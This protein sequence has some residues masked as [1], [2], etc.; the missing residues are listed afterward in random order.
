MKNLLLALIILL[1]PPL[2]TEE[3]TPLKANL[4]SNHTMIAAGQDFQLLVEVELESGWHAYWKNPGDSGMAP[5]INWKLPEGLTVTN[6]DW[7]TPEKFESE[8]MITYGYSSSFPLL[9]TVK[10]SKQL[11]EGTL[12]IE[13]DL[14][15]IICS[16]ETCLPGNTA[17]K[18]KIQVGLDAKP[19][20]STKFEKAESV[21]PKT[22]PHHLV[23]HQVG[24]VLISYPDDIALNDAPRFFPENADYK[25]ELKSSSKGVEIPMPDN[26]E[27][28]LKGVLVFGN[29]A[30][31]MDLPLPK[32]APLTEEEPM[33]LVWAL[34]F[35]VAGGLILNLMPCV[36]PVVSL[37][38]MSFVKMAGNSRIELMK[39]GVSFTFGVLVSFWIL[40]A[41]LVGLQATGQA[42]GWGFQLQD[43]LF[44]SALALLFTLLALNLFGVFEFGT[45]LATAAGTASL[46]TT[47]TKGYRSS[48]FSGMFATAIATPC[49]GPFMGSALGYAIGQPAYISFLIF[50]ALGLG[51]SLPYLMIGFFPSSIRWLPK[52]GAWMESFKQFLGFLMLATVIWLLWVFNGQTSELGLFVMLF[53]LLTASIG[54][55][56]YGRFGA[57]H[58]NK[59]SRKISYFMT[60][61]FLIGSLGMI[62]MASGQVS[63]PDSHEIAHAGWEPFSAEK[64]AEL[65]K[66][67]TPILIDFTAKWCLICQANHLVM[68]N[69]EVTKKFA[70]NGVV[71]MKA[72]W[73]RYD[74]VITEALKK[75]GRSGVPLYVY[76]SEGEEPVILP[77]VLTPDVIVQAIEKT[78]KDP[79]QTYVR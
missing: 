5:S 9:I 79:I 10:T 72:D 44:I 17:I 52:P 50:T 41:L 43:P 51:M 23:S 33:T 63:S 73:T 48:F 75:Y 1:T 15:W 77:Q 69:K 13:G 24:S 37:K 57:L 2:F 47:K 64:V 60:A 53:A 46:E 3:S 28:F 34:L 45:S 18:A 31:S 66:T 30:Y 7:P 76:Y 14:Q 61:V 59:R 39:Q 55:W 21:I 71:L 25:K 11:N 35:A 49:T 22:L 54:A 62:K 68:T 29:N 40:A 74:P 6:I 36:L 4:T 27:E 12:D 78:K 67:K 8:G 32:L 56:I 26:G 70:E 65:R 16:S 38:V 19:E 58:R 20:N 42:V